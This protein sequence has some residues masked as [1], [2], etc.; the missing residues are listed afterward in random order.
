MARRFVGRYEDTRL[1][2]AAPGAGGK[3]PQVDR[4]LPAAAPKIAGSRSR[5]L[6]MFVSV[7]L[8]PALGR[9]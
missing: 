9:G 1:I 5:V 8:R 7:K 3:S 4:K 6:T 2:K